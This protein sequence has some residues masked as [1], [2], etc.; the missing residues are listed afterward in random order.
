MAPTTL[1]KLAYVALLV[2]MFGTAT[3]WLGG[4]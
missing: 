1:Q 2:V 4:L 3:G